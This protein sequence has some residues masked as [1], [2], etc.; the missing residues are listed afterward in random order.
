MQIFSELNYA[1]LVA[2]W[3]EASAFTG[4]GEQVFCFAINTFD[5][6]KSKMRIAAIEV[7][8]YDIKNVRAPVTIHLLINRI[9]DA[10]QFFAIIR[11]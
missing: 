8:I 2:A 10:F 7:F 3:A 6:G 11:N 4:K 9:P 5:P 1:P